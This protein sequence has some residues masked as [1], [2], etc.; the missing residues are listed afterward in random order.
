MV[1]RRRLAAPARAWQ[2]RRPGGNGGAIT[3]DNFNAAF[4]AAICKFELNCT[5]WPPYASYI[6]TLCGTL[7]FFDQSGL[8]LAV[9]AGRI[10]FD[11]TQATA[12]INALNAS[13]CSEEAILSCEPWLPG[14]AG[15]GIVAP[16]GACYANADCLS[17]TCVNNVPSSCT[18]GT[19]AGLVALG[20]ACGCPNCGN[21]DPDAGLLCGP[22]S[23]CDVPGAVGQPCEDSTH[24]NCANGLACINNVCAS[25]PVSAGNPCLQNDGECAAGTYCFQTTSASTGNCATKVAAGQPCA[26]DGNHLTTAFSALDNECGGTHPVCLG[27][28]VLMDAGVATGICSTLSDVGGSCTPPP[29]V[30]NPSQNYN[31]GC[32]FGLNCVTGVCTK[33]PS[34]GP[35]STDTNQCDITVS[36]CDSAG[37]GNCLPYIAP[38]GTC[39]PADDQPCGIFGTC[40]TN[41]ICTGNAATCSPTL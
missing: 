31:N 23:F 38:G 12:C 20:G 5:Q 9:D 6:D 39:N 3:V 10:A 13:A 29:G 8:P 35:C 19:C 36:F 2:P 18:A 40:G 25:V 17:A 41:D 28:G 21:C 15:A 32:Y 14:G 37:T 22:T 34:T 30:V 33:P 1:P 4:N 7:T 26:E 24:P 11:V 27:A 16:A